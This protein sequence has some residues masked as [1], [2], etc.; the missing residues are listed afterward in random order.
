MIKKNFS[1]AILSFLL[2]SCEDE[3]S[4]DTSK[5]TVSIIK[6]QPGDIIK[7]DFDIEVKA[8]DDNSVDS[9]FVLLNND[10]VKALTAQPYKF[11]WKSN[12]VPDGEYTLS[13]AAVDGS[14]NVGL[15]SEMKIIVENQSKPVAKLFNEDHPNENLSKSMVIQVKDDVYFLGG[16]DETDN[17]NPTKFFY[18]YNLVSKSWTRLADAPF[19][20][21]VTNGTSDASSNIIYNNSSNS[22]FAVTYSPDRADFDGKPYWKN[23]FGRY[24]IDRDD[25]LVTFPNLDLFVSDNPSGINPL[26][27]ADVMTIN[28]IPYAVSYEDRDGWSPAIVTLTGSARNYKA[29]SPINNARNNF[30]LFQYEYNNQQR[31]FFETDEF[32]Y[33]LD[34]DPNPASESGVKLL[35]PLHSDGI[36]L[37]QVRYVSWKNY[38]L[39]TRNNK[40]LSFNL[41]TDEW[42]YYDLPSGKKVGYKGYTNQLI[43][44]EDEQGLFAIITSWKNLSSE[45]ILYFNFTYENFSTVSGLVD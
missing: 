22:I 2:L 14:G 40:I 12:T 6:P 43:N 33:E 37:K 45:D 20:F 42:K 18:K 30:Q 35:K 16:H 11:T 24:R 23:L 44:I 36:D 34:I 29:L 32:L 21:P 7:G 27:T 17:M 4:S 5:P 8:E 25:W 9:V 19:P 41:I 39:T 31:Y 26:F 38:L 3:K 13:A 1:L 15:S 28:S 10:E